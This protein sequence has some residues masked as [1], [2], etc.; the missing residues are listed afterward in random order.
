MNRIGF[1]KLFLK[2]LRKINSSLNDDINE[3]IKSLE[4]HAKNGYDDLKKYLVNDKRSKL[5]QGS[6]RGYHIYKYYA[7]NNSGARI[8]Y[9]YGSDI[10]ENYLLCLLNI[11]LEH[12]KQGKTASKKISMEM[13]DYNSE[14]SY[15]ATPD[16]FTTYNIIG[17]PIILDSIQE[18]MLKYQAPCVISGNAGSGKTLI[19]MRLMIANEKHGD[20]TFYYITL[21]NR[22]RDMVY[23]MF[24]TELGYNP[25]RSIFWSYEDLVKDYKMATYSDFVTFYEEYKKTNIEA[26]NKK[27]TA[28]IRKY[29]KHLSL[30]AEIIY[31]VIR[32]D[33]KGRMTHDWQRDLTKPLLDFDT[34]SQMMENDYD[35]FDFLML[36]Y[37]YDVAVAY[38][39]FLSKKGLMDENDVALV[40]NVKMDGI[41]LDEAQDF[42]ELQLYRFFKMCDDNI[43]LIG[44]PNQV[45]N[46]SLFKPSRFISY[47]ND[48]NIP[49]PMIKNYRSSLEISQALDNLAL[50]RK[51]LI[52]SLKLIDEHFDFSGVKESNRE[53]IINYQGKNVNNVI[54]EFVL[55]PSSA[56]VVLNDETKK[57]FSYSNVF[58]IKEIKGLEFKN[59]FL[60]NITSGNA[61]KWEY[62]LDRSAKSKKDSIYRY[63]FN[64]LYVGASRAIEN[65]FIYEDNPSII[66]RLGLTSRVVD[67]E[68]VFDYISSFDDDFW[69]YYDEVLYYEEEMLFDE[70]INR[71]DIIKQ[72][73]NYDI[74]HD[75]Y[76]IITKRALDNKSDIKEIAQMLYISN[77]TELL[78][79]LGYTDSDFITQS[80]HRDKYH[81][82]LSGKKIKHYNYVKNNIDKIFGDSKT[83]NK[84]NAQVIDRVLVVDNIKMGKVKLSYPLIKR[85]YYN[86]ITNLLGIDY[87]MVDK[88]NHVKEK[89]NHP[90]FFIDYIYLLP[91]I[92]VND[93]LMQRRLNRAFELEC[94]IIKIN[95]EIKFLYQVYNEQK[96]KKCQI[97]QKYYLEYM[98]L[99]ESIFELEE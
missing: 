90:A 98:S 51:E 87:R 38:Q 2:K 54:K 47:R 61:S 37:V 93:S 63:Y 53:A 82:N 66:Q 50:K 32:R 62:I 42:T 59:I 25:K 21:T 70:A 22:L 27:Y 67:D 46:P 16:F 30:D 36:E 8:I 85:K 86:D 7:S 40:M 26:S 43:Y 15:E 17:C 6:Y 33:I 24:L 83:F 31:H 12:K 58:T 84:P 39:N 41:V 20:K 92:E 55:K 88:I 97:I 71:L 11:E 44:D 60:Y 75:Y 78:S 56:L 64:L 94:E 10:N 99:L 14:I 28:Y 73:F 89:K 91:R 19:S 49:P 76:R 68:D 45:I 96:V 52:S 57:L 1:T 35:D 81:L 80:I 23:Q 3:T 72:K 4:Q 48:I 79:S 77:E 69:D 18:G 5:M 13:L 9:A 65:I 95:A 74:S 34:F 29:K